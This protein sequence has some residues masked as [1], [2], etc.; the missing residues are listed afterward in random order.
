MSDAIGAFQMHNLDEVLCTSKVRSVDSATDKRG[1]SIPFRH[2][3]YTD[4][5]HGCSLSDLARSVGLAQIG[6]M[7]EGARNFLGTSLGP[8]SLRSLHFLERARIVDN[9]LK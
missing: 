2:K 8:I 6:Q 5:I 4:D 3:E 9:R 1:Y 7:R